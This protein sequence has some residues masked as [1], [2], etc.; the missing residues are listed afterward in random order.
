[1]YIILIH[2]KIKNTLKINFNYTF[3]KVILRKKGKRSSMM[4]K[5]S[6]YS[7]FLQENY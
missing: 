7:A 2:F 4:K 3:K 5:R 6:I 1:M